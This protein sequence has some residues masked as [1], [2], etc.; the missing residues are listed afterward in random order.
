MSQRDEPKPRELL[1]V[2][3]LKT[4]FPLRRGLRKRIVGWVRAVDGVSFS[5]ARGEVL[6]LV[7]ESGSGKTTVGRTIIRLLTPT[8]GSILFDGSEIA[9][10]SRRRVSPLRRRC[11]LVFQDP[12]ASLHPRMRVGRIIERA[13]RMSG[14]EVADLKEETLKSLAQ[15][16]LAADFYDRFPHELSGGQQQRVGV[17][18]A[19]AVRP[20]FI[21]LDEPTSALDL[22][23]Q[24]QILNLL[25]SLREAMDLTYLFISHDLRVVNYLCDRVAV[26]Y[27][28]KLVEVGRREHLFNSAG[29]PYTL[30]LMESVPGRRRSSERMLLP[31][32]TP[33]PSAPPPGCRFHTRCPLQR[34]LCA[35][36]E[37][38]L[39]EVEPDHWLACHERTQ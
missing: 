19:L 37:P 36:C 29:H 5:I 21:V 1:A 28:G 4:Y 16:N 33:S 38:E 3:G 15:V 31:G 39:I 23:V 2:A 17:A 6:G 7:G 20:E 30:A 14:R 12:A 34:P 9:H 26:M 32:E 13:L 22:S 35:G 10:L 25:K 27:A 11:Q 8:A 24:A 18:R